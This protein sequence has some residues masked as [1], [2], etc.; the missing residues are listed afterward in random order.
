[1]LCK[2]TTPEHTLSIAG[3]DPPATNLALCHPS[4][5]TAKI[6]QHLILV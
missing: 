5:L 4:C 1:M 6:I 3:C 2:D